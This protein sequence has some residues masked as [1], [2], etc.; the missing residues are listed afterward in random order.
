MTETAK[1]LRS[2]KQLDRLADSDHPKI[3]EIAYQLT[4][5]AW[6]DDEKVRSLFYFVRDEIRFGFPSRLFDLKASEVLEEKMGACISKTILFKALL[7]AAGV[8]A[9]FH[10]G[11]I[12]LEVFRGIVPGYMRWVFPKTVAHAW[13]EVMLFG[14]WKAMD[15]FIFDKPYF[16]GARNKLTDEGLDRGYGL[17]CH[18]NQCSCAFHFGERGFVQ[19]HAVVEDLGAWEDAMDFYGSGFFE[20]M[21]PRVEA[22]YPKMAALVNRRIRKIRI[23]SL[24]EEERPVPVASYFDQFITR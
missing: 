4:E 21:D 9:R 3:R 22:L 2:M 16:K 12:D 18:H 7:D 5:G 23:Q 20:E 11:T 13:L 24:K 10:F 8:G 14:E 15:S 19:M 1:N 17:A 6:A